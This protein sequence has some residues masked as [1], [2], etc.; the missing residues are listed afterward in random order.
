MPQE[1]SN[2]SAAL[3][4]CVTNMLRPVR[5]LAPS[6]FKDLF[7][8]IRYMDV[9]TDVKVHKTHVRQVLQLMR[10]YKFYANLKKSIFAASKLPLLGCIVGKHGKR[11]DHENIRAITNWPVSVD[12][13]GL[14]KFLGLSA[15]LHEYSRD[16]AEI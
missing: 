14:G 1:L 5:Y 13:K 3:Y 15:Y 9:K 7:F 10:K 4:R 8:Q 6:Y 16:Y 11:P 12:V 2:S